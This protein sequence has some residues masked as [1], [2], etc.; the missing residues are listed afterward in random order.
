M[1]Q[2]R[3]SPVVEAFKKYAQ[4]FQ[5]LD[6]KAVAAHFHEPALMITPQGVHAL[7]NAAAVEQ[8]YAP[9]MADLPAKRYAR[10][11]FS[12]FEER[13]LSGDLAA[14]SGTGSWVDTSGREFA[15]FGFTYTFLRTGQG[16]RIVVALI[17]SAEA[18]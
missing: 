1:D 3:A 13:R 2:G 18:K 6:P 17:H 10:T 8:A 16:W 11:E 12:S 9:V 14:L 5:S 7:P 15:P 4:A